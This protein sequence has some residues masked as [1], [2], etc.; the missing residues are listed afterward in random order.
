MVLV[1]IIIIIILFYSFFFLFTEVVRDSAD[2]LADAVLQRS[3]RGATTEGNYSHKEIV[4]SHR[5]LQWGVGWVKVKKMVFSDNGDT[6][7][8]SVSLTWRTDI[9]GR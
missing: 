2:T 8:M 6:C 7:A 3:A 4:G 5:W 9:V 1:F